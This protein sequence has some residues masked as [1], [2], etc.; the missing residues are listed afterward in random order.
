MKRTPFTKKARVRFPTEAARDQVIKKA[1][2]MK[3]TPFSKKHKVVH[4]VEDPNAEEKLALISKA[5]RLRGRIFKG[6][7]CAMCTEEN[8]DLPTVPHHILNKGRYNHL[9]FVMMNLIPLCVHHHDYAHGE[10]TSFLLDLLDNYP[11]HYREYLN[12]RDNRKPIKQTVKSLTFIVK[13]MQYYADNPLI[14]EQV[15]YEKD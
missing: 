6:L 3:R 11:R 7:H 8:W 15:I 1:R 14:A 4:K 9:R 13:D 2:G 12:E 5:A 10:Q